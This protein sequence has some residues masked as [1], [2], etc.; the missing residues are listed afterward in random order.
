MKVASAML[1]GMGSALKSVR[2]P[3]GHSEVYFEIEQPVL[4]SAPI[5]KLSAEDAEG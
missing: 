4:D 2:S 3:A 5:G 1:T